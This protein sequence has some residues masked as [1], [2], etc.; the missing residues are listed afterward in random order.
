LVLTYT[1][2]TKQLIMQAVDSAKLAPLVSGVMEVPLFLD[3]DEFKFDDELARQ[4]GVVVL[5]VIAAGRPKRSK[6]DLGCGGYPPVFLPSGFILPAPRSRGRFAPTIHVGDVL[7]WN[8][9]TE[10]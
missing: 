10:K 5:N 2:D 8:C 6:A 1:E 4:L 3:G 9:P 7:L